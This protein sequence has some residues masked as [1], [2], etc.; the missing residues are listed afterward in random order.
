MDNLVIKT[1]VP[2]TVSYAA[3]QRLEVVQP[4]LHLARRGTILYNELVTNVTTE[5]LQSVSEAHN[6]LQD[7]AQP[8]LDDATRAAM[9]QP[10]T[11][12]AGTRDDEI[13][14]QLK[15]LQDRKEDKLIELQPLA[16]RL[17][18]YQSIIDSNAS[19]VKVLI[20]KPE[21]LKLQGLMDPL[22]NQLRDYNFT[23]S[24][25]DEKI[26]ALTGQL[27]SSQTRSARFSSRTSS[28][29]LATTDSDKGNSSSSSTDTDS[30]NNSSTTNTMSST[31][32]R[33]KTNTISSNN[34]NI[35]HNEVD[36]L[37]QQ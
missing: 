15:P 30:S 20:A 36:L 19:T 13:K 31:S 17:G 21:K 23:L 37:R 34:G 28:I 2:S 11:Q 3:R 10:A 25:I 22:I 5:G 12:D 26:N 33:T 7:V 29:S 35:Q 8:A 1:K 16:A 18:H 32:T 24:N 14:A 4:R 9:I 6:A 27:D